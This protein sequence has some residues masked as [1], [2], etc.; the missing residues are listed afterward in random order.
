MV[1]HFSLVCKAC[2]TMVCGNYI[3]LRHQSHS[4][5][6]LQAKIV[7]AALLFRGGCELRCWRAVQSEPTIIAAVTQEAAK[8]IFFSFEEGKSMA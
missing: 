8:V 6:L 4:L 5:V 1:D 3:L 7:K 2:Y